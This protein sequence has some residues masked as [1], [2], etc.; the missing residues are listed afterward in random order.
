M[1]TLTVRLCVMHE[2]KRAPF[3]TIIARRQNRKAIGSRSSVSDDGLTTLAAYLASRRWLRTQDQCLS[4]SIALVDVLA[5]HDWFPDLV[6]GV[7]MRP[8]GAHAW[9]AW[10][11]EVLNDLPDLVR[12][13]TPILVV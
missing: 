2:L 13:Y 6:L 1:T 3:A 10:E 8:F 12:A 5:A 11:G 9:V 7:K 4:W